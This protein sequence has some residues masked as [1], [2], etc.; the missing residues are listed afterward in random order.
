MYDQSCNWF[1][2]VNVFFL[3][4]VSISM[5]LVCIRIVTHINYI[6]NIVNTFIQITIFVCCGYT[7]ADGELINGDFLVERISVRGKKTSVKFWYQ[8]TEDTQDTAIISEQLPEDDWN[9]LVAAD[10]RRNF[11]ATLG[12]PT[13]ATATATEMLLV[14]QIVGHHKEREALFTFTTRDIIEN[15]KE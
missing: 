10:K 3:V 7:F 2:H 6:I 8:A 11:E 5:F 14:K 12:V 13:I 4:C 15:I 9:E 1:L